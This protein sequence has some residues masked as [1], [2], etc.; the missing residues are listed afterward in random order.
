MIAYRLLSAAA[1]AAIAFSGQTFA[2]DFSEATITT[3]EQISQS[4]DKAVIPTV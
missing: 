2:D 3:A 1:L 4:I